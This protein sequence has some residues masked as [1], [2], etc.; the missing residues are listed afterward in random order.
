MT[1]KSGILRTSPYPLMPRMVRSRMVGDDLGGHER[2]GR[3][4][5]TMA[6]VAC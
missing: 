3:S 2:R 6:V 4:R 5:E 1:F